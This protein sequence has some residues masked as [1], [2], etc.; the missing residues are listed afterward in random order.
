MRGSVD[1]CQPIRSSIYREDD[2]AL[3][4]GAEVPGR[5]HRAVHAGAAAAPAQ[6]PLFPEHDDN[7]EMIEIVMVR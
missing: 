4:A 3:L 1:Q 5:L 6:E 2:D 7:G